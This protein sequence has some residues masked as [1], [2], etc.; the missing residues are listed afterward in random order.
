MSEHSYVEELRQK[1]AERSVTYTNVFWGPDA[2]KLSEE[3]RARH[4]LA[5]MWQIERGHTATVKCID[6]FPIQRYYS[7]T[8]NRWHWR[9]NWGEFWPWIQDQFAKVG[10]KYRIWRDRKLVNPYTVD[11]NSKTA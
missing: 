8:K 2:Y 6:G 1:N 11:L 4:L 9:A 5:I 7:F 3:E 10:M